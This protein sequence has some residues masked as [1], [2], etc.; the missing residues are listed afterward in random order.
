MTRSLA[1]A[2]LLAVATAAVAT[3]RETLRPPAVE[4]WDVVLVTICL[5]GP[6]VVCQTRLRVLDPPRTEPCETYFTELVK[7]LSEHVRT[8]VG[9]TVACGRRR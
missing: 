9:V 6:P 8:A 7:R 3:P 2:A 5:P 4:P 1:L